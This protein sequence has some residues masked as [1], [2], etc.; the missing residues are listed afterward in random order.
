MPLGKVLSARASRGPVLSGFDL[1]V[2]PQMGPMSSLLAST[3]SSNGAS[4]IVA[5]ADEILDALTNTTKKADEI[6]EAIRNKNIKVIFVNNDELFERTYIGLDGT[7]DPKL[8]QAFCDERT[9]YLRGPSSASVIVHEG[10][11]ALDYI[12]MLPMETIVEKAAYEIR[13]HM[14]ER[15]YSIF[16]GEDPYFKTALDILNHIRTNYFP[17]LLPY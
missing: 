8:V 16:I 9:I 17:N 4:R 6:A 7:R 11:H 2:R 12:K 10:T 15:A 3:A 5:N 13:A 14:H 1:P